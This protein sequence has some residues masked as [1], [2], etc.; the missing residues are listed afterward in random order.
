MIRR[1]AVAGGFYPS[2][3]E[4]II[5]S[6]DSFVGEAEKHVGHVSGLKGVIVPHAGYVYSGPTAAYAYSLINALPQKKRNVF[7]LGPA[8]YVFTSAAVGDFEAFETPLGKIKVNQAICDEL[9]KNGSLENQPD[10]HIPEHS[11]EVQ[12]PFIQR[13]LKDFEIVPILFGEADP[14][15]ISEILL[16]YFL[17]DENLFVVSSDLSHYLP[18]GNAKEKDARTLDII[19]NLKISEEKEID[20]CGNIG[21]KIMMHM[22]RQNSCRITLLDYRNSGDTAGDKEAVVGYASLAV[23]K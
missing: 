7:I 9:L 23:T 2:D 1:A 18:Y 20:A 4:K 3:K 12:L 15:K 11:L 6:V 19:T 17:S 14:E 21:I 22:A 5:E 8:H 16:P 13:C 10:A